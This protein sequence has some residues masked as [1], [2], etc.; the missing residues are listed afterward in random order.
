LNI[1][2]KLLSRRS[3]SFLLDCYNFGWRF[4]P[5]WPS[6]YFRV[7]RVNQAEFGSKFALSSRNPGVLAGLELVER[8]GGQ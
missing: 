1:S 4:P 5:A 3:S 6:D 8:C 7:D 2:F